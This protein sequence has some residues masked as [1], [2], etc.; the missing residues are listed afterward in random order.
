MPSLT[1]GVSRELVFIDADVPDLA[2]LLAG[3]TP[4]ETAYVLDPS[5]D[6]LAEIA[7]IIAAD[8]DSDLA[9]IAIVGHGAAGQIEV[10]GATLDAADLAGDAAA[11]SRIGAALAPGGQLDL[12]ACNTAAGA[13]GQTFVDD[14]SK[15]AGGVDIVASNTWLALSSIPGFVAYTN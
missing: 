11:L 7:D 2:V 10:G 3:L 8:H 4:Q 5:S 1:S 15:A 13:N 6:G 14:L 9:S 12:Y